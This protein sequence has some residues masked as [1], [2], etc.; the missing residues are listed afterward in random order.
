MT[1]WE[2]L[3]LVVGGF[4]IPLF[5][6]A[7][8]MR[9]RQLRSV[10]FAAYDSERARREQSDE[11]AELRRSVEMQADRLQSFLP[12][13]VE[14]L[15]DQV[16]REVVAA[17]MPKLL[18]LQSSRGG[19]VGLPADAV[20][21]IAHE[22]STVLA[23]RSATIAAPEGKVDSTRSDSPS[24]SQRDLMREISHSLNTP[25][26]QISV[27]AGSAISKLTD[28]DRAAPN[29]ALSN[30]QQIAVSASLCLAFLQAFRELTRVAEEAD[31]WP[32]SSLADATRAAADVYGDAHHR[33][34]AVEVALPDH[35]A[36][37]SDSYVTALILPLL[38]NAIE[39]APD[40]G[41]IAVRHS[42]IDGTHV[43][44]VSNAVS[45]DAVNDDRIYEPGYTTKAGHDGLGLSIVRRL[46]GRLNGASLDHS[47]ES[48]R[49][50]F[51]LAL[52]GPVG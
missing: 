31:E 14:Q 47:L 42:L 49:V 22:L 2:I 16:A 15:P 43:I 3:I 39:A 35:V 30:V 51:R 46:I 18:E 5:G 26:S 1:T 6:L 25:L 27:A 11:M 40:D 9:F 48:G 12:R 44:S 29:G 50:T 33:T 52:P 38:E 13:L 4:W 36:G 37:Y 10:Q 17:L 20:S 45:N 19:V 34:V 28:E 23:R 21:E 8:L 41:L 7:Q 32:A 24:L